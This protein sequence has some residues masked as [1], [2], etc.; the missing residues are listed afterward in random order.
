MKDYRPHKGGSLLS[1]SVFLFSSVSV[2]GI[3][4]PMIEFAHKNMDAKN[5][6]TNLFLELKLFAT[7]LVRVVLQHT[8]MS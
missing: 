3:L 6:T 5:F 7:F 8:G 2:V 1:V 4:C